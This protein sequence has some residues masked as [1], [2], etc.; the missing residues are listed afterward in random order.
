MALPLNHKRDYM[1]LVASQS[2]ETHFPRTPLD[3]RPCR[4]LEQACFE[5][6]MAMLQAAFDRARQ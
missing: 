1:R 4:D 2:V 5:R 6:R 3:Q